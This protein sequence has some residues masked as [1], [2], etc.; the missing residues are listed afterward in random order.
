MFKLKFAKPLPKHIT[1]LIESLDYV[2]GVRSCTNCFTEEN[3]VTYIHPESFDFSDVYGQ[4][5]IM[6]IKGYPPVVVEF[7][8]QK[9]LRT[10]E[11]EAAKQYTDA[12]QAYSDLQNQFV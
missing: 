7:E 3:A 2:D 9:N 10:F 4:C 12:V 11:D 6:Q 5:K 1:D 8:F